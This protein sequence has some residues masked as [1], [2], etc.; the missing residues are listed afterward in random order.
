[1]ASFSHRRPL[2]SLELNTPHTP[3]SKVNKTMAPARNTNEKGRPTESTPLLPRQLERQET[4]SVSSENSNPASLP[5]VQDEVHPAAAATDD[6]TAESKLSSTE[7]EATIDD[8]PP[9]LE[10]AD[11]KETASTEAGS[12]ANDIAETTD[13]TYEDE[14]EDLD[15]DDVRCLHTCLMPRW[16]V[17]IIRRIPTG[18]VPI[19]AIGTGC[20]SGP[21]APVASGA[22]VAVGSMKLCDLESKVD[23]IDRTVQGLAKNQK[24]MKKK[25]DKMA[26]DMG[27]LRGMMQEVLQQIK[28]NKA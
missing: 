16:M 3:R 19:A 28:Q 25:I 27:E 26:E 7:T 24:R 15:D 17:E 9:A 23:R 20:L 21:F 11:S 12:A 2:G 14:D 10:T 22:V 1:M 8:E 18:M 5:V 6:A 13:D 4:A